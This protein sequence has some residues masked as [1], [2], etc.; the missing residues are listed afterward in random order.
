MTAIVRM[1]VLSLRTGTELCGARFH[2]AEHVENVL[3]VSAMTVILAPARSHSPQNLAGAQSSR[4]N[5]SRQA[6]MVGQRR[7]TREGELRNPK[8]LA[9]WGAVSESIVLQLLPGTSRSRRHS[10]R[11]TLLDTGE[12]SHVVLSDRCCCLDVADAVSG[13]RRRG[14]V[15]SARRRSRLGRG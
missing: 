6:W 4:D 11:P 1:E 15:D 3:H 10:S 2:R 8:T 5:A 14:D 13:V 7:Q 9:T 12:R